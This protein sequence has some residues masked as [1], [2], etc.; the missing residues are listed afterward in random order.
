LTII[1]CADLVISLLSTDN[2]NEKEAVSGKLMDDLAT[3]KEFAH[4]L[5]KLPVSDK[6]TDKSEA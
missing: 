4:T 5:K 1:F 3:L 2:E 6:S